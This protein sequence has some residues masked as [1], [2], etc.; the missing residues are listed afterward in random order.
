MDNNKFFGLFLMILGACGLI[1][2]IILFL[3]LSI[4]GY[5][6][7]QVGMY[8]IPALIFF[9]AGVNLLRTAKDD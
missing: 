4:S 1:Y 2:T 8:A 7:K 9:F 6:A 3:N 5:C